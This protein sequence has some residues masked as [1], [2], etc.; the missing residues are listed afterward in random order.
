[1]RS[2]VM[3]FSIGALRQLYRYYTFQEKLWIRIRF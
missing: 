3:A 2:S 1:M